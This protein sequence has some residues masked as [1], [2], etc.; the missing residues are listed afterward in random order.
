MVEGDEREDGTVMPDEQ[1]GPGSLEEQFRQG[2]LSRRQFVAGLAAAGF[3]AS[4]I[5]QVLGAGTAHA[6]VRSSAVA[7]YLCLIV[8]DGG[9]PTYITNHLHELPNIRGLMQHARWY[10]NAWVGSLM[11]ITPPDHAVIGT[12]SLPRDNGGLVNWEWAMH[13][14]G[15]MSPSLQDLS[16]YDND[17]AFNLIRESGTPTLAG[18][19]R[20]KYPKDPVIAGSAAHFHA[21]GPL[22]GPDASWIFWYQKHAGHWIPRE[23]GPNPVPKDLLNDPSLRVKLPATTNSTVPLYYSP[24][25]LGQQDS[26]VVDFAIKA[27]ERYQPRGI[28]INLPEIDAIG[29]WSLQWKR[30]E[31]IL[32]QSFDQSLGRLLDA[33]KKAGIYDRTLFVITADHGMIQSTHRVLDR[34]AVEDQIKKELGE[35]SIILTN[36]GGGG[37]PTMTS[38]WLKD[39]AQNE[40]MAKL[41]WD[42]HYDNVSAIYY[43]DGVKYHSAGVEDSFPDLVKAYDYL[44]STEGAH[45]QDIAILLRENA[46]NSGLPRMLGRHGGADWGSQQATLIF[47]GP[48][49]KPGK[50][51]APARLV[52]IA[53]TVERLMGITPNARD[54]I[55]LADVFE[56]P[57]PADISPHL[58]TATQFAPMVA[59][60]QKRAA[61]DIK[62]AA[63]G[64][65]PNHIP[66]DEI[67]FHWKRVLGVTAVGAAVMLGTGAALAWAIAEVRRQ[68]T[69]LQWT[70]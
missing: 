25:M 65:L 27:L 16:N 60:L 62:L 6:E 46:R 20:K 21:A 43:R 61:S 51:N 52:D 3:T 13:K 63:E 70:E 22:G 38:I 44:L 56:N 8:L 15:T 68:G 12:G 10:N 1:D 42:K 55:V 54:G 19:I 7:E 24:L 33:Y 41:I 47:S 67:I 29:H 69:G 32:Y 53:P 50:S 58:G 57:H 30:D 18:E 64:N 34:V 36:G 59:A 11:S 14:T 39:P 66:P 17:W 45:G 40:R 23:M 4:S 2:R 35:K 49:V 48:G 31:G 9:R 26:L 5:P 28:L 37:G